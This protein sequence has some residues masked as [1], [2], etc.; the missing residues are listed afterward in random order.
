MI[1]R[2]DYQ[3]FGEEIPRSSYG[4]DSVRKKFTGYER[5]GETDLDSPKQDIS[6]LIQVVCKV[7]HVLLA[8][9]KP[10]NPQTFNRY[11]YTQN[12]P[13]TLTDP[14]GLCSVLGT[15]T[16]VRPGFALRHT[17]KLLLSR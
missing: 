4:G 2:H 17:L 6:V 1:A 9:G 11:V 16:L 5:D 12:R 7:D 10:A 8:S 15:A 14:S 3:P 13:L